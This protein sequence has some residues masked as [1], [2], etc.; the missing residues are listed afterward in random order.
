MQREVI[1]T[2]QSG[3]H[4]VDPFLSFMAVGGKGWKCGKQ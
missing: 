2:L 3:I 1:T 4:M